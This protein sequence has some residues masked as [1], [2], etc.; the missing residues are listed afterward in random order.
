MFRFHF[1]QKLIIFVYV[2]RNVVSSKFSKFN[3]GKSMPKMDFFHTCNSDAASECRRSSSFEAKHSL[4][5]S[6]STIIH[7]QALQRFI[8]FFQ[9]LRRQC[10]LWTWMCVRL[11]INQALTVFVVSCE[12]KQ[13]QKTAIKLQLCMC[14]SVCNV[15]TNATNGYMQ[16]M[17]TTIPR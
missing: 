9:Y 17:I 5:R 1:I 8:A 3:V 16:T 14:E 10:I 2:E 13:Q 4:C 11:K 7:C 15:R 6:L 12:E